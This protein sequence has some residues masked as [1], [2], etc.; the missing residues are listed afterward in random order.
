MR[1]EIELVPEQQWGKSLAQ[2]LP[3]KDW[4]FLRK[5]VYKGHNWT[6]QVCGAFGVKVHCHEVWSYDD[7]KKIQKLVDL[8]CLCEDCHNIKHWGRTI[9]LCHAGKL[10]QEYID[11]LR[12]HFCR[13]NQCTEK[14][15]MELIVKAGEK[16]T[17]RSKYRYKLNL[18]SLRGIVK[19]LDG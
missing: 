16:N 17:K 7:R 15:M 8:A 19:N 11:T 4:D 12:R 2:L 18:S 13:V 6:C 3:K 9:Q 10:S 1:L 14:V 5:K